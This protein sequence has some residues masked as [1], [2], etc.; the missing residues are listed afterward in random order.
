[1][2]GVFIFPSESKQNIE[3]GIERGRWAV[4]IRNKEY[5]QTVIGKSRSM[6][7]GDRVLLYL[8]GEK[9]LY[10]IFRVEKTPDHHAVIS[11]LWDGKF[12]LPFEIKLSQKRVRTIYAPNLANILPS[13]RQKKAPWTKTIT[14][15]RGLT[16]FE[17]QHLSEDDMTALIAEF[18]N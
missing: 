1:M 8:K 4:P 7:I 15:F 16:I 17:K 10:G 12:E 13:L 3:L 6:A 11:D 5:K 9:L 2:D 18:A 14:K